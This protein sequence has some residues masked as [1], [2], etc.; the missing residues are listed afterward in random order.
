VKKNQPIEIIEKDQL[1]EMI[2][3]VSSRLIEEIREG[4]S[5]RERAKLAKTLGRLSRQYGI[6]V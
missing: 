1:T 4:A 5:K 3:T 6:M 2:Q